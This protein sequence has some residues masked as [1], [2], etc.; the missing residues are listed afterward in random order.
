MKKSVLITW[1]I[2]LI[3]PFCFAGEKEKEGMNPALLVIDI[4]QAYQGYMDEADLKYGPAT[5]NWTMDLFHRYNCPVIRIYHQS[6]EGWPDQ[7]STAFQF[8][9]NIMVKETDPKIVKHYPN[10]FKKT[11]LEKSLRDHGIN[12]VFVCGYNAVGCVLATYYGA[13]DLDFDA[14]TVKDGMISHRTRYTRSVEDFTEAVGYD[15]IEV[16]LKTVTKD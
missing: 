7:D 12:T 8:L 9:E 14:F 1:I 15:A 3:I 5:I 10:G 6:A 11:E 16:M 4:Q 13:K 2:M